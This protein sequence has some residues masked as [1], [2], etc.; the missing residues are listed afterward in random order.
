MARARK[1]KAAKGAFNDDPRWEETVRRLLAG[2][3]IRQI[4]ASLKTKPRR[5]R[6]A[7]ARA[8]VRAAGANL[9]RAGVLALVAYRNRLGKEPDTTLARAAGVTPEAVQG[10]RRRLG[11]AAFRPA[12]L[13]RL[14]E[15]ERSWIEGLDLAAAGIPRRPRRSE[16]A[17]AP[18]VVV[19][20]P[21]REGAAPVVRRPVAA[22][23]AEPEAPR[24]PIGRGVVAFRANEPAVGP[25]VVPPPAPPA[26]APRSFNHSAAWR[27]ETQQERARELEVLLNAPERK[28]SER[29]RIVR[30]DAPSPLPEAAPAPVA[31]A[32]PRRP[33]QPAWR[34]ADP[35]VLQAL[36]AQA[37]AE[38]ARAAEIARLEAAREAEAERARQAASAVAVPAAAA[39]W[40]GAATWAVHAE[41]LGEIVYV[42]ADDL[43]GAIQA[44]EALLPP[45]RFPIVAIEAA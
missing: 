21:A 10:E 36:A 13:V 35:A 8:G 4:A 14:T 1:A 23:V 3:P 37:E 29:L 30:A 43:L 25:V 20:K 41:G 7:F 11:I 32:T 38:A 27:R 28:R 12:P 39:G 42:F 9:D 40:A 26:P 24:V 45:A 22:P 34:A 19:K 18:S 31:A 5:L 15:A 17:E 16:L 44:A 33:R 6:R 2:E